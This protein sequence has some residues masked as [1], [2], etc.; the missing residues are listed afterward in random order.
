MKLSIFCS[1]V[2]ALLF[3]LLTLPGMVN[4]IAVPF[5]MQAGGRR[6]FY[7]VG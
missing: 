4:S 7:D 2:A 6:T 1:G 3:T 5:G